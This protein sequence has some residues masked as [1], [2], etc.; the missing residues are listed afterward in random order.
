MSIF[1]FCSINLSP[2]SP[3]TK[4]RIWQEAISTLFL[5]DPDCDIPQTQPMQFAQAR[6]ANYPPYLL[7]FEG[8]PA[9]RHVENLKASPATCLPLLQLCLSLA[10]LPA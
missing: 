10:L 1:V 7:G 8:H 2:S 3:H 5:T 6:D 4:R 9:E